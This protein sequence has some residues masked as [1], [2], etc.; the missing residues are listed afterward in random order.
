MQPTRERK[1]EHER[2]V[3]T[4]SSAGFTL[5]ELLVVIGILAIL[6]AVAFPAYSYAIISAKK[7]KCSSNL[8][9]IGI[10]L[11]SFAADNNET[12]PESGGT[13]PY[14]GPVDATTGKLSWTQQMEP[15]LGPSSVNGSNPIYQCPGQVGTASAQYSYFNGAHAAYVAN[16]GHF[17]ALN[18]IKIHNTSAYTL[19]GDIA[20]PMFGAASSG[21]PDADPDDYTSDPAFNGGTLASPTK[22]S[23]HGGSSNILFAD[24]HVESLKYF[25]YTV[26]TTVYSGPGQD[27]S[28]KA[29]DYLYPN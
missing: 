10:G 27:S 20:F 19:A 15:Y 26:N 23:I 28:G 7:A 1:A 29:Y 2:I 11:L 18:L 6:A 13:I 25:D 8:R 4:G 9:Q 22:I 3:Q 5:V 16:S 17:A 24:G 14:G 12:F 21:Q